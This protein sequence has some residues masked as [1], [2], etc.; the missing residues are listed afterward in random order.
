MCIGKYQYLEHLRQPVPAGWDSP[1]WRSRQA[2]LD[3]P[4]PI[5]GR[6]VA[7]VLRTPGVLQPPAFRTRGGGF[8][9]GP[10]LYCL[11]P[12]GTDNPLREQ[13]PRGR[14]FRS[15]VLRWI[16]RSAPVSVHQISRRRCRACGFAVLVDGSAK[17]HTHS[18]SP[19]TRRCGFFSGPPVQRQATNNMREFALALEADA[20]P[21]NVIQTAP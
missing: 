16:T 9:A 17:S 8:K 19:K 20:K 10:P 12:Y 15:R 21:Q 3:L 4:R 7:A 14:T 5:R 18:L 1:H 6:G 2:S 11:Q 13:S